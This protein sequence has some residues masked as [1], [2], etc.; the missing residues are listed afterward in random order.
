MNFLQNYLTSN[1]THDRSARKSHHIYVCVCISYRMSGIVL[2][3]KYKIV[4]Y[5]LKSKRKNNTCPFL[6]YIRIKLMNC[7]SM[8]LSYIKIYS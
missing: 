6:Q 2:N 7:M 3:Y 5:I 4:I 8:L 1:M